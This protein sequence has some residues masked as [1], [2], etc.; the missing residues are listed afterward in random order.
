LPKRTD[1]Y[2]KR[3]D[4]I[5]KSDACHSLSIEGY[6]VTPELIDRVRKG[7]WDPEHHDA[8]RQNRDA[9]AARGSGGY[10]WTIIRVEDR[11]PYLSALDRASID[12]DINPFAT[13]IAERV[14]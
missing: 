6:N 4:E 12:M 14:R 2:L 5:Y 1:Q 9:L 10:P 7:N 13:F 11:T 3:V 8:D